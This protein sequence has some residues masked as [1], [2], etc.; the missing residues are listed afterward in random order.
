MPRRQHKKPLPDSDG[1]EVAHGNF[2]QALKLFTR[3][4]SG[5]VLEA[6]RRSIFSPKPTRSA[7]RRRGKEL[8]R[9]KQLREAS[10]QGYSR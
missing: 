7:R 10:E 3:V 8:E 2:D 5:L 4:T 6:K 9:R 1:V